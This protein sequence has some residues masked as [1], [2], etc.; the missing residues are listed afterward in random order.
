MEKLKQNTLAEATSELGFA[1]VTNTPLTR[2]VALEDGTIVKVEGVTP[3]K[4]ANILKSTFVTP[5]EVVETSNY[6]KLNGVVQNY[7]A[8]EE[9]P[10]PPEEP[11]VDPDIVVPPAVTPGEGE[12]DGP[13]NSEQTPGPVM[14]EDDPNAD[15][16]DDDELTPTPSE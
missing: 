15:N 6:E 5:G 7:N 12:E 11:P 10:L 9:I 16:P 2:E 4:M 3:E 1:T 13:E 14:P 8:E